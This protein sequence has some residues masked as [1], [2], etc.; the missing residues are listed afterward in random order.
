MVDLIKK[1]PAFCFDTE[2]T[3][4]NAIDAELVGMAFSW[5]I[6]QGWYVPVPVNRDEAALITEKFRNVLENEDSLI[7]G[8]N[9]KY[10]M[11]VMRNYGIKINN[12]VFDTMVAHYLLRPEQKHNLDSLAEI[13]LDY[14]TIHTEE[15]IGKKGSQ[16]GNMRDVPVERLVDY[17]CEDTD[18][19]WQLYHILKD[20]LKQNGFTEL[21]EEIEFPLISVLCAMERKRRKA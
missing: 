17:A 4:I 19:T 1:Q 2:T 15:L 18:I 10:D 21:A 7:I 20:E 11:Q 5:N 8:Q 16:Q 3:N 12:P 14:R 6:N 9:I 13:Y